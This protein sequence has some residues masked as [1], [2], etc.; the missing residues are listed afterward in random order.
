M[1]EC[2]R[3]IQGGISASGRPTFWSGEQECI[4]QG[5]VAVYDR[6]ARAERVDTIYVTTHRLLWL[7]QGVP[8]PALY[9]PLSDL[10][11]AQYTGAWAGGWISHAKLRVSFARKPGAYVKLSFRDGGGDKVAE[12]LKNAMQR[13]AW[14]SIPIDF[15]AP[16]DSVK[17]P[18]ESDRKR[19]CITPTGVGVGGI[20][21][22]IRKKEEEQTAQVTDAFGDVEQLMKQA[23]EMAQLAELLAARMKAR[24]EGAGSAA[25]E[26]SEAA[27]EAALSDFVSTLGLSS[28]VSRE[29]V[30]S[31]VDFHTELAKQLLDFLQEPLRRQGGVMT[32][33]DAYCLYNKARRGDLVSPEDVSKACRRL[34]QLPGTNVRLLEVDG[35]MLLRHDDHAGE[36]RIKQLLPSV[37]DAITAL[38][39]AAELRVSTR[40]AAELLADC[41]RR[42]VLCRDDQSP[43][44][45]A[46]QLN[47]FCDPSLLL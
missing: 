44:G 47:Y 29:T 41:C 4:Q 45:T 8:Q 20:M 42:G 40:V 5:G 28:V 12:A 43:Q 38:A 15:E 25:G 35:S 19:Y 14:E 17:K 6:E 21:A 3:P 46:Y 22:G 37:R 9:A 10:Q 26:D 24:R 27:Q 30:G 13:K 2:F 33:V 18:L 23:K 36:Q 31:G 39:V 1:V 34:S 32:V 11:D 16:P 7:R